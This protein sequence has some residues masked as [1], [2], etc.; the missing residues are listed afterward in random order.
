M[1]FVFY[2]LKYSRES[3]DRD[4]RT[5]PEIKFAASPIERLFV[6]VTGAV[7]STA[8]LLQDERWILY[9]LGLAW[10]LAL[11][12]SSK[13]NST[14]YSL[15]NVALQKTFMLSVFCGGTAAGA[16]I[17]FKSLSP[18]LKLTVRSSMCGGGFGF[19][20]SVVGVGLNE[21][22]ACQD[23][24]DPIKSELIVMVIGVLA[25][26][27]VGG[28]AYDPLPSI[29]VACTLG[30]LIGYT[31]AEWIGSYFK[32]HSLPENIIL[33]ISKNIL[34]DN[35]EHLIAATNEIKEVQTQLIHT[36]HPYGHSNS[37]I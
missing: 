29:I 30:N 11:M 25:G 24:D 6:V 22:R 35:I 1:T 36:E 34:S 32:I 28:L 33:D 31:T 10:I 27:L 21:I 37:L 2:F 5:L 9:Y 3:N 13:I 4:C 26:L 23:E 18:G 19:A 20:A 16:V 8:A 14:Y 15:R 12:I 7:S 17:I